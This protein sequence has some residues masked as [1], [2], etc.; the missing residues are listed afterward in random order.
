[1]P[2]DAVGRRFLE[3]SGLGAERELAERLARIRRSRGAD[4]S[5]S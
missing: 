5:E 4:A 2:D 3:L 1:M